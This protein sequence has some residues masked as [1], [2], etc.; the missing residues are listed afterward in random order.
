MFFLALLIMGVGLLF[1]VSPRYVTHNSNRRMMDRT[2]SR[3]IGY[4]LIM[5]SCLFLIMGVL[6]MLDQASHHM[7]H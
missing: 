4:S 1:I 3:W 5:M 2:A 7:D 6:Q